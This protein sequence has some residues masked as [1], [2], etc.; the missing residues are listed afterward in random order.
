[1]M[2]DS[3]RAS[4]SDAGATKPEPRF[5]IVQTEAIRFFPE[6]VADRGGDPEALLRAARIDTRVLSRRGSILEYRA[7]VNLFE[8]AA[9]QLQCPD[10]GMRLAVRQGGTRVMGPIGIVMKNSRT[11]GQALGYCARQIQAYSLATHVKFVPNRAR[12]N[13]FVELEIRVAGLPRKSQLIEHDLLLA[14]LNVMDVTGAV[15]RVRHVSFRHLPLSPADVYQ[16]A[17]G[18]QVSFGANADGLVFEERDLL[19]PVIHADAEVHEMATSFIAQ[20]F[21][22]GMSPLYARVR[23]LITRYLSEPDCSIERIAEEFCMQPRKL[24]RRLQCEGRSFES[25]K[26]E[27]RREAALRYL[28]RADIPFARVAEKL[29]YT[30]Y[31]SLA[32]SCLRWFSA[33]PHEVRARSVPAAAPA[34]SL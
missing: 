14:A 31:S 2:L 17:F 10:F 3:V 1:M 15:A 34:G 25:T 6:L 12:H 8:I 33:S 24:Q 19:C 29:G 5:D 30:G 4:R 9:T 27:V 18:C 28:Q 16:D 7:M 32:R 21:P 26:D 23:S 20:H 13:L 22:P 11:L